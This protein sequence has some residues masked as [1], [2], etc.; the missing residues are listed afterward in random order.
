MLLIS[1]LLPATTPLAYL[2]TVGSSSLAATTS[3]R[4]LTM[5]GSLSINQ[6]VSVLSVAWIAPP[7]LAAVGAG[8]LNLLHS[9][10]NQQE[11]SQLLPLSC[12]GLE[13]PLHSRLLFEQFL[14]CLHQ[15]FVSLSSLS[16][17][18]CTDQLLCPVETFPSWAIALIVIGTFILHMLLYS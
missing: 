1:C 17:L 16:L 15:W 14:H 7:S 18:T 13:S 5:C 4:I 3:K 8:S 9:F 10:S 11:Q 6:I 2:L 12:W